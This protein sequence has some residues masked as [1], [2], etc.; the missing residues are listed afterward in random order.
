MPKQQVPSGLPG[1]E[2]E[3]TP[4]TTIPE[5]TRRVHRSEEAKKQ[6]REKRQR[7]TAKPRLSQ[8]YDSPLTPDVQRI[9]KR[10][11]GEKEDD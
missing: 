6:K 9:T 11:L 10:M 4:R 2:G 5:I 7:H 3:F 1:P 8:P